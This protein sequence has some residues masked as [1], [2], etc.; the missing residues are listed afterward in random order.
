MKFNIIVFDEFLFHLHTIDCCWTILSSRNN[1]RDWVHEKRIETFI[2]DSNLYTV[3]HEALCP[4]RR[5]VHDPWT[6]VIAHLLGK[7]NH[8]KAGVAFVQAQ[9][10][11]F[12]RRC[13]LS[14]KLPRPAYRNSHR[15]R[16]AKHRDPPRWR[17]YYCTRRSRSTRWGQRPYAGYLRHAHILIHG[18]WMHKACRLMVI[19]LRQTFASRMNEITPYNHGI[20]RSFPTTFPSQS[21]PSCPLDRQLRIDHHLPR[22]HSTLIITESIETSCHV[23]EFFPTTPRGRIQI[24]EQALCVQDLLC[25]SGE[26]PRMVTAGQDLFS[27]I[28][29]LTICR[30]IREETRVILYGDN[31]CSRRRQ[32]LR[33]G[34]ENWTHV[35]VKMMFGSLNLPADDLSDSSTVLYRLR[36]LFPFLWISLLSLLYCSSRVNVIMHRCCSRVWRLSLEKNWVRLTRQGVPY[37]S[38]ILTRASYY[39]FPYIIWRHFICPR[40]RSLSWWRMIAGQQ[41]TW[42]IFSSTS[43]ACVTTLTWQQGETLLRHNKNT[44]VLI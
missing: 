28:V 35:S 14:A 10:R 12:L 17:T 42:L 32:W 43:C 7:L 21:F 13:H 27:S 36:G 11:S 40:L 38:W 2:H 23:D 20:T 4:S 33:H 37:R 34:R 22:P 39:I 5:A 31:T 15:G 29:L 8:V 1:S 16:P 18:I 44:R 9:R 3:H 19:I 24:Y 30:G 41:Y 6:I 25:S 26:R